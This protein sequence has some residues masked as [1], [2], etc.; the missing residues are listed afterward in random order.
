MKLELNNRSEAETMQTIGGWTKH[1][2]TIS[3]S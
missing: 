1:C 3:G 2:S